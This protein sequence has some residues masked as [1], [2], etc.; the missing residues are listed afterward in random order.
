MRRGQAG[1]MWSTLTRRRILA[2]T[3]G[4]VA[5]PRSLAATFDYADPARRGTPPRADVSMPQRP[6]GAVIIVHGGGFVIGSRRML[7][8]RWCA[9]ALVEAGLAAVAVDYRLLG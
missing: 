2:A 8:V 5:A 6:R 7:S 1:A 9:R 3:I 4:L